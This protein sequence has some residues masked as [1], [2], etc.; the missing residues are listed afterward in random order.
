MGYTIAWDFDGPPLFNIN[1]IKAIVFA[2]S[3]AEYPREI[4][5]DGC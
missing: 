5:V 3:T 1:P 2:G 4:H